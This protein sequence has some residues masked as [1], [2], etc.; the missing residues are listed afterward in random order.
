MSW[1]CFQGLVRTSNLQINRGVILLEKVLRMNLDLIFVSWYAISPLFRYFTSVWK[2]YRSCASAIGTMKRLHRKIDHRWVRACEEGEVDD[3]LFSQSLRR[4]IWW[5][6]LRTH[7]VKGRPKE[8]KILY[9]Q[10]KTFDGINLGHFFMKCN[11]EN[12]MI[13][14]CNRF[15]RA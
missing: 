3:R 4:Q 10:R 7:H 13:S 15:D 1:D 8:W 2:H 11:Q 6:E 12:I 5:K 9:P 14:W